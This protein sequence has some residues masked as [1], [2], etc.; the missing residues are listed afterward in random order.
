MVQNFTNS[1]EMGHPFEFLNNAAPFQDPLGSYGDENL[2]FMKN[3]AQK[4][5]PDQIFQ[6]LVP[7]GF[8]VSKAGGGS[9]RPS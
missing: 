4:Y 8:K 6:T 7:G 9:E 3:V 2:Q 5:D 1:L